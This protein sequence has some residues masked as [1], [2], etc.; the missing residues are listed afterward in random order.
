[1]VSW[2]VG[3]IQKW[4]LHYNDLANFGQVPQHLQPSQVAAVHDTPSTCCGDNICCQRASRY[5]PVNELMDRKYWISF[6]FSS[7][8]GVNDTPTC[9]WEFMFAS[10]MHAP[11][12]PWYTEIALAVL[13]NFF[14]HFFFIF[15]YVCLKSTL[16]T[17]EFT[18]STEALQ[19]PLT[20]SGLTLTVSVTTMHQVL[21]FNANWIFL[22]KFEFFASEVKLANFDHFFQ[23]WAAWDVHGWPLGGL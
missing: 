17:P 6:D 8:L 10:E 13:K 2:A 22:G 4:D 7:N 19:P 20:K 5:R 9:H 3:C 14:F 1:M 18:P 16:F 23:L 12:L 11:D 15:F 21:W